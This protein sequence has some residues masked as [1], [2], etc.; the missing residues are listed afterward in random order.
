MN[1][2]VS[3]RYVPGPCNFFAMPDDWL[4]SSAQ[5]RINLGWKTAEERL[6]HLSQLPADWDSEGCLAPARPAIAGTAKLLRLLRSDPDNPA[7]DRMVPAPDGTIVIEWQSSRVRREAEILDDTHIE[8][9]YRIVGEAPTIEV[10]QLPE[11]KE[12]QYLGRD[13]ASECDSYWQA[14]G[15]AHSVGE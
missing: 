5:Y 14:V 3:V 4:M 13:A 10:I 12:L 2:I 8:W 15:F 7:P 6:A 9:M 11:E 1:E